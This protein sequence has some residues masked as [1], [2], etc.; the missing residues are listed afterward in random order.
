MATE[1]YKLQN[2]DFTA[3]LE[4]VRHGTTCPSTSI[5]HSPP[6]ARS[7]DP[8]SRHEARALGSVKIEYNAIRPRIRVRRLED[9]DRLRG[10]VAV[11]H[12][13]L[14]VAFQGFADAYGVSATRGDSPAVA[15]GE[16]ATH[17]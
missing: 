8:F 14:E 13:R 12:A 15:Q 1:A 4:V 11:Q 17:R 5:A 7:V 16:A 10:Q 3:Q 9:H 2:R 6:V